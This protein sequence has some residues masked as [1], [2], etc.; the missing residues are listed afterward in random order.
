M[1]RMIS[2]G[3]HGS[4]ALDVGARDGH[5]SRILAKRFASVTALDLEQPQ[6]ND[7]KINFVSG[8]VTELQFL[9]DKFDLVV[10]TEV[11]EHI[12]PDRLV[13][14]CSELARMTRGH[15]MIGVPFKQDIRVGQRYLSCGQ[16]A[17]GSRQRVRRAAP[18]LTVFRTRSGRTLF[19]RRE[20]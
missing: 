3:A 12:A 1:V 13:D 11:L 17:V 19:R 9:D 6:L 8:D 15:L 16:P 20:R 10:C 18:A 4:S 5:F 7:P 2:R 14:A